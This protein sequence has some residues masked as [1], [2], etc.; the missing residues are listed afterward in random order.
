MLDIPLKSGMVVSFMARND[1][2]V[3]VILVLECF[4]FAHL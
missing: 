3:V 2:R 1:G 4:V